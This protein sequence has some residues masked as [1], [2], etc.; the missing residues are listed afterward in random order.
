MCPLAHLDSIYA[1]QDFVT[2][3]KYFRNGNNNKE[4][5]TFTQH[6]SF[7][8]WHQLSENEK[9]SH[10]LTYCHPCATFHSEFSALHSSASAQQKHINEA[11]ETLTS[12][13]CA[14]FGNSRSPN[15]E[16]KGIKVIKNMIDVVQPIIENKMGITFKSHLRDNFSVKGIV[17]P[18]QNRKSVENT[19]KKS[20]STIE[21]LLIN[22]DTDAM[23]FLA[24][25][26]SY[27][28]YDRE[29][30][31]CTHVTKEVAEQHM[32]EKLE[33]EKSRKLKPKVHHG[34]FENYE[35]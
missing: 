17:S 22:N 3:K 13:I 18:S 26:K 25:G 8:T 20:N 31:S 15:S 6:F 35:I 2:N 27:S 32:V 9:N 12:E 14:Q 21:N 19:V 23:N 16:S 30:M 4:R 11:R 5:E 33:K 34:R 29:R 24:S 7:S 1:V 10:Q 28:M